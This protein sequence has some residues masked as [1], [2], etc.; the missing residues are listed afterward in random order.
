M[1][2][3]TVRCGIAGQTQDDLAKQAK[4]RSELRSELARLKQIMGTGREP[5]GVLILILTNAR[6]DE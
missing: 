4:E 3:P 2:F 1:R 5:S 6:N